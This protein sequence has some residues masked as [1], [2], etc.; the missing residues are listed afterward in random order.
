MNTDFFSSKNGD[1]NSTE[2]L[3]KRLYSST[4]LEE[5]HLVDGANIPSNNLLDEIRRLTAVDLSSKMTPSY[6]R[7]QYF[8][9]PEEALKKQIESFDK[10]KS[11]Q[12]A[13]YIEKGKNRFHIPE[14]FLS[15]HNDYQNKRKNWGDPLLTLGKPFR[16]ASGFYLR[17]NGKGLIVNPGLGFMESFHRKGLHVQDIDFVIITDNTAEI[18]EEALAIYE[19]NLLLNKADLNHHLIQYYFNHQAYQDLSTRFKLHFKQ[20]RNSF[21]PLELFLDS[22]DIEK[23]ELNQDITLNYFSINQFDSSFGIRLDLKIPEGAYFSASYK[24]FNFRAGYISRKGWSSQI[25]RHLENCDVLIAAFGNTN[26]NDYQRLNYN[27]NCLGYSGCF[28][29]LEETKPRLFICSEFDGSKGDV[30]LEIIQKLRHD[31]A[32]VH[33]DTSLPL[34][35]PGDEGFLLDL[36]SFQ[37]ECS[38]TKAFVDPSQVRVIKIEESFGPLYYLSSKSIV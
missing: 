27:E 33:S 2:T 8:L 3:T 15:L 20:E 13:Q 19:L 4:L 14:Y 11:D 6:Q 24:E 1:M 38:L 31:L 10:L 16:S 32:H 5:N 37:V 12:I 25:S 7:P 18:Y 22:P 26:S 36:K 30:R 28:T 23:I 35:L 17:W 34:V 21:H 9:T 29:L